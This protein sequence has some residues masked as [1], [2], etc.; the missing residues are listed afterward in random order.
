MRQERENLIESRK[1]NQEKT[2]KPQNTKT[3]Q[4]YKA[5][6]GKAKAERGF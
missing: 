1:R 6:R 4:T 5:E 3:H 2:R